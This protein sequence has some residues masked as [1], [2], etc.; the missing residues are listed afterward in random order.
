MHSGPPLDDSDSDYDSAKEKGGCGF[1][2]MLAPKPIPTRLPLKLYL[3]GKQ[4][5]GEGQV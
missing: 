3:R 1:Q 4:E 2:K 5:E